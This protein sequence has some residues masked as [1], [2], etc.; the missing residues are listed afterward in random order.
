VHEGIREDYDREEPADG[1]PLG[2]LETMEA[3]K[4]WMP[5]LHMA[6][7]PE[8][9]FM[10]QPRGIETYGPCRLGD[11]TFC[12]VVPGR[13]DRD[14]TYMAPP[15]VATKD[16]MVGLRELRDLREEWNE[17]KEKDGVRAAQAAVMMVSFW[18]GRLEGD[19]GEC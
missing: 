2:Y 8:N 10:S 17:V 13:L 11:F 18:P 16:E 15:V 14:K 1:K 4:G 19:L 3:E 7:R 6:V 9:L 12:R 5:I